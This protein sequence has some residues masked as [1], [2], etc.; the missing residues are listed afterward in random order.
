MT[1]D[2]GK[3][4]AENDTKLTDPKVFMEAM[5]SEMRRVMKMEMDYLNYLNLSGFLVA[6]ISTYQTETPSPFVASSLYRFEVIPSN[7][8]IERSW[9][10]FRCWVSLFLA[11]FTSETVNKTSHSNTRDEVLRHHNIINSHKM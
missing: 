3:S 10:P 5:M 6:F 4:I 9:V 11:R 8:S 7:M 1:Q 2:S